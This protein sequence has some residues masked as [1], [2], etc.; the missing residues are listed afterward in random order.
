MAAGPDRPKPL[1]IARRFPIGAEPHADGVHFRVWAPTHSHVEV[2]VEGRGVHALAADGDGYHAGVIAAAAAGDRYRLSLDH[3][4]LLA[5]PAS[6][7][8][9]DGPHGPSMLID[10]SGFRWTDDEWPGPDLSMLVVYELHIGTFTPAGTWQA[11]VDG[12]AALAD[13]GVTCIELMPVAEFTGRFGWGYDGVNLF[14]PTRLYGTPDDFRAF[15]NGAHALG[16]AVILDVVY[17][18]VGPDG[19]CLE[20]FAPA[21][22]GGSTEWGRAINFDGRDAGP[23]REY[24]VTNAQ[25]WIEEFH[26]DGLRLDAVQAIHDSSDLHI[27]AELTAA[28]RRAAGTR[29]LWIVGEDEPQHAHL[30]RGSE[31]GGV[32][33]DALWNDDFHHSAMVAATGRR[34]A[35]FTDYFGTPQ[36]FVSAA[37]YG[38]LYQGQWYSWQERGR[39]TPALG[40]RPDGL[41]CFLQNH[42]QVANGPGGARLHELTSPAMVRALTAVLLLGPWIPMLFQGQE[43]AADSP[44]CYFADH[45]PPLSRAVREG[46]D[47]FLSQFPSTADAV[48]AGAV[49]D[50]HDPSTFQ[51]S[52]LAPDGARG[53]AMRALHASLLQLRVSD[54]AF[55]SQHRR[56][57]DGAVLGTHA[58]VFR[59]FAHADVPHGDDRLL[60]V[61]LGAQLDRPSMPEPLLA[62]PATARWAVAW[63]SDDPLYGGPGVSPLIRPSGWSVP[64]ESAT[65]LAPAGSRGTS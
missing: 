55:R 7:F 63:S 31:E 26:L 6:R 9:P 30:L 58:F 65:V 14:A 11:A 46:R 62:P 32:G 41:V 47:T 44:F 54:R 57:L 50:P 1:P 24:F 42:D 3:G 59:F 35:Y 64:A 52:K 34:E 19:D 10:P 28:A 16:L 33:I 20:P 51:R 5:D 17:N 53:A 56:G 37:K 48:A 36:E 12:L 13:L 60:V 40:L 61:N 45:A 49:P 22:F 43:Y 2:H 27:V 25:Y 38:F 15:V 18:H 23:V 4:P 8:Q 21:F 39:G 29:S